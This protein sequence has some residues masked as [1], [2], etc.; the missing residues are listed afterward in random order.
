M[1]QPASRTVRAASPAEP[2]AQLPGKAS[3]RISQLTRI[4]IWTRAAGHCQFP[5]CNKSLLGD[6]VA[7]KEDRNFGFIAHIVAE[8]A[9][10][11]RGDRIRSPQ[12]GDD[13]NNLMLLCATHHKLIDVD[14]PDE[15]PEERLMAIKAEQERRMTI[16]TGI[17]ADRASHVLRY[18]A[19]IGSRES[20][21]AFEH[22]SEAM[23]PD[24]YPAEGRQTIDIEMLGVAAE[25]D[26]AEYWSVQRDNLR[27]QFARK[28]HERIEAR[29]IRHLSVFGLAPQ[30]LLIELGHLLGDILAVDVRQLHRE[31]KGWRWASD[32]APISLHLGEGAGD[33]KDVALVVALSGSVE[34]ARAR[35]ALGADVPLWK[36]TTDEPHNDIIRDPGDLAAF[37]KLMR[38]AFD[39]IKKRHGEG[40]VIHLFPAVPVSAAVEIGRVWMPKADLPLVLWDQN[41]KVGG[42]HRTFAIGSNE[43][44]ASE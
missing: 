4:V 3:R 21:L 25:D 18:G 29:D 28:V 44:S 40:A 17:D 5:G 20:P 16:V 13:P 39:A 9:K 14:F 19:K 12:L 33:G 11:P 8:K 43:G 10:G 30:P 36:I 31:P 38:N 6:L 1:T 2:P 26:E 7:G 23:L 32:T 27:R 24:R 41:R 42:F 15:Y 22:L 35:A 34:P 37:R